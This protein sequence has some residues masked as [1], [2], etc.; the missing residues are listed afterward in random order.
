[1]TRMEE[2]LAAIADTL[3]FS[4]DDLVRLAAAFTGFI[5][6]LPPGGRQTSIISPERAR[7][8]GDQ[9]WVWAG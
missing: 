6:E 7:L 5:Q 8:A 9:A 3:S 4:R 2:A 1:M